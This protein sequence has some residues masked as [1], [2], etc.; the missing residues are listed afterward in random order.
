M[1][2]HSWPGQ[3]KTVWGA[4]APNATLISCEPGSISA[5]RQG[6][7]A[8]LV[9]IPDWP[10]ALKLRDAV[11]AGDFSH[12]EWLVI[13]TISTLQ[14]KNMNHTLDSAVAENS[15]RDPDIPAIQDYQKNQN[16][17]KRWMERMVDAPINCLFL[18][19]TMRVEDAD[20]GVMFLPAI[21][22]GPDKGYPVS[23]YIMGLMNAVGFMQMRQIKADNGKK[24]VRRI[25]WQPYHDADKDIRYSAKDQFDAFGAFTDD[26][27]FAEHIA[28]IAASG[29]D[30]KEERAPRRTQRRATSG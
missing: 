9:K 3:G 22:G 24:M 29:S 26:L 10:T 28:M 17:F 23:N 5:K 19:H 30:T 1:L 16:S 18:A 7:K 25:L 4:N 15:R 2:V 14:I 13:D 12:R 6:S 21:Q 20:G 8:G 27:S 11:E